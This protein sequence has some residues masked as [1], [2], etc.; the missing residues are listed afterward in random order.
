MLRVMLCVI[1]SSGMVFFHRGCGGYVGCTGAVIIV[2]SV[3]G[4]AFREEHY[5]R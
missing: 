5:M 2:V 1:C 3:D 4:W